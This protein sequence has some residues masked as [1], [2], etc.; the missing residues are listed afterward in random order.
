MPSVSNGPGSGSV[1]GGSG[2]DSDSSYVIRKRTIKSVPKPASPSVYRAVQRGEDIPFEGLQMPAPNRQTTHSNQRAN[3][4]NSFDETNTEDNDSGLGF[5]PSKSNR[6]DD[7]LDPYNLDEWQSRINEEFDCIYDA[8]KSN[9]QLRSPTTKT[10]KPI[11]PKKKSVVF[12]AVEEVQLIEADDDFDEEDDYDVDDDVN[13]MN[14]Y[15]G[16]YDEIEDEYAYGGLLRPGSHRPANTAH[17]FDHFLNTQPN[18]EKKVAHLKNPNQRVR[19]TTRR[20]R[21]KSPNKSNA[22]ATPPI[23]SDSQSETEFGTLS[24][25]FQFLPVQSPLSSPTLSNDKFMNPLSPVRTATI[26]GEPSDS[27]INVQ[28][29]LPN[30]SLIEEF[31]Y[32]YASSVPVKS[33]MQHYVG[34]CG[35]ES[36]K[37]TTL[38]MKNLMPTQSSPQR[39]NTNRAENS[40]YNAQ[41]HHYVPHTSMSPVALDRYERN[42]NKDSTKSSIARVLFDFQ[43]KARNELAVKKGDLVAIRRDI[44]AQWVEVEDCSSGLVGFVPRSYLDL[45]QHG[46]AKAKFDFN[47]KTNVEISFKKGEKLILLRRIDENWFEGI[48]SRQEIGIFPVS[49]VEVIKKII[50]L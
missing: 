12:D 8:L 42:P 7:F 15:A 17:S 24:R 45:D 44:N 10:Q 36:C 4:L 25:S 22:G 43:A 48:N 18:L 40:F 38:V 46:L 49:Y 34:P 27:K 35:T 23:R 9:Q 6:S 31:N 1:S 21:S 5:N 41:H 39:L 28:Y 50:S 19:I 3:K 47:A 16:E 26:V 11:S 37:Q 20:H 30:N 13:M 32:N 33:H 14:H 29:R 2:Y